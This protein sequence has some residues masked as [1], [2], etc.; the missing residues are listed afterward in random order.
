MWAISFVLALAAAA[1]AADLSN[2]HPPL[3]AGNEKAAWLVTPAAGGTSFDVL[4]RSPGGAWTPFAQR[5]SG[6]VAHIAAVE[7]T[8]QVFFRDPLGLGMFRLGSPE[9]TPLPLPTA[10]QWPANTPPLAFCAADRF[11]AS[12]H[13]ALLAIVGMKENASTQSTQPHEVVH[14]QPLLPPSQP[15]SSPSTRAAPKVLHLGVFQQ[16]KGAWIQT[17]PAAELAVDLPAGGSLLALSAGGKL[18]LVLAAPG[19]QNDLWQL[20]PSPPPATAI[21]WDRLAPLPEAMGRAAPLSALD[22]AGKPAFVVGMPQPD[23]TLARSC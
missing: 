10:P 18:Y 8:L 2:D 5:I 15:T 3:L 21:H 13:T 11:G 14:L 19:C 20:D 1:T 16:R 17:A 4:V 12:E 7:D 6:N 9:M 22:L 23:R